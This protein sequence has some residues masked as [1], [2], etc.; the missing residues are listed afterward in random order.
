M[1][2]GRLSFCDSYVECLAT[3]PLLYSITALVCAATEHGQ[4]IYAAYSENALQQHQTD[5]I[6]WLI[7]E[8]VIFHGSLETCIGNNNHGLSFHCHA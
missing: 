7:F 2:R 4:G 6:E 8:P 5:H 1:G 3:V